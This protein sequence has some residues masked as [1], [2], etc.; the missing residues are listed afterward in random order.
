MTPHVRRSSFVA[1]PNWNG[2]TVFTSVMTFLSDSACVSADGRTET[3]S[4]AKSLMNFL[5]METFFDFGAFGARAVPRCTESGE[6]ALGLHAESDTSCTSDLV[7]QY[8]MRCIEIDEGQEYS[9]VTCASITSGS[10]FTSP[11]FLFRSGGSGSN[12]SI[13]M[14]AAVAVGAVFLAI[15]TTTA[16]LSRCCAGACP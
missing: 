13:I 1:E 2:S 8:D 16:F 7:G 12:W 3:F 10:A 5:E 6:L 9:T 14:T 11:L 4:R 15:P